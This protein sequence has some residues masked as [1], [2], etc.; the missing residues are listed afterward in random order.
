MTDQDNDAM[1]CAT[2]I[3]AKHWPGAELAQTK[4]EFA[5]IIARYLATSGGA[6]IATQVDF[7]CCMDNSHDPPHPRRPVS[8]GGGEMKNK[9]A[10]RKEHIKMLRG[11]LTKLRCWLTGYVDGRNAPGAIPFSAPGHDSLRMTIMF[12]D[13]LDK[14]IQS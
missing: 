1:R 9:N 10:A 7:D 8:G 3:V 6:A 13:E 11:Q 14:E 12:L 2:E 5:A 4:A